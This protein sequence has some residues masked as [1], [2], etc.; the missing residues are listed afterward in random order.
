MFDLLLEYFGPQHWWP[1]YTD[2]EI[3]IG[4]VLTQNTNWNNVEKAIH[5]LKKENLL[6][7]SKLRPMPLKELADKIRPAGYF[8]VKARRLNNLIEFI[9]DK[10]DLDL[11]LLQEEDTTALRK[12]LL[13]VSGIGPETA[14]SI[15]L[16]AFHRSVFVV[17]SYT[18]RILSRHGMVDDQVTYEELQCLFQDQ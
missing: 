14:D 18:H 10:Y 1:G 3:M 4:A 12:G 16:C 2:L 17:D 8:N 13:T 6:S 9:D 15:L 11:S 5:N 7:L